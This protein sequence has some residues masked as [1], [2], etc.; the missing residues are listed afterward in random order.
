MPPLASL[1]LPPRP[2]SCSRLC[3]S[4][5]A[6]ASASPSAGEQLLLQLRP[7]VND[8][9]RS[10]AGAGGW[11]RTQK[12]IEERVW[13]ELLEGARSPRV[14]D[15]RERLK[16]SLEDRISMG[17]DADEVS[18]RRVQIESMRLAAAQAP[19]CVRRLGSCLTLLA[20]GTSGLC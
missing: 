3:L 4:G 19:S 16:V 18:R 13:T 12:N 20:D 17:A 14:K 1:S 2:C 7:L 9:F 10:A 5:A 8:V 6:A 15:L 11:D